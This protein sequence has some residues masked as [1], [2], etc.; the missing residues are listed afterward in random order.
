MTRPS[1]TQ[2]YLH[3][4][5]G[6]CLG[7]VA[8]SQGLAA[9]VGLVDHQSYGPSPTLILAYGLGAFLGALGGCW[10]AL[11]WFHH[12]QIAST[13]IPLLVLFP[14]A[15]GL[16]GVFISFVY[17]FAPLSSIIGGAAAAA[18]LARWLAVRRSA[19]VQER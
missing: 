9:I 8:A 13:V 5:L 1:L 7:S 3:A 18:V 19:I 11:A 10:L 15:V 12:R 16:V 6:S 14:I 2:G 17:G 4:I